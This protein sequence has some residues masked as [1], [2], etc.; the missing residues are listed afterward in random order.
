MFPAYT[1]LMKK[2]ARLARGGS[3]IL[4]QAAIT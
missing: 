4:V 3:I 2:A 1:V